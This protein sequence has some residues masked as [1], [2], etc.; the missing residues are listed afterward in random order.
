MIGSAPRGGQTTSDPDVCAVILAAGAGRRIGGCKALLRLGAGS[1]LSEV[2]RRLEAGGAGNILAVLGHDA[3]R[4][5]RAAPESVEIV[6]NPRPDDGMLGSVLLGIT[7]AERLGAGSLLLLPVDHPLVE[8]DTIARVVAAL[9]AGEP[10]VVPSH[11]GRRGHPG[12]FARSVWPALR[13]APPSRGARA[14]L[15]THPDWILHVQGDPGCISG[16]DTRRDYERLIGPWPD[17]PW[18]D[19]AGQ[20]L[21]A[22]SRAPSR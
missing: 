9:R 13:A 15:A 18:I 20:S 12:G 5:A 7:A 17:P 3:E 4:V 6:V 16:I 19:V 1:F 14:V 11:E 21:K 8:P 10:I 2:A 22:A